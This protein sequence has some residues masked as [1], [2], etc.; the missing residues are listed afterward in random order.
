VCRTN[1]VRDLKEL[2]KD[3]N[4]DVNA[5]DNFG[6]TALHEAV[7]HGAVGCVSELLEY[8]PPPGS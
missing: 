8:E 6:W 3:P 2:L 5:V 7:H 1:K 4:I